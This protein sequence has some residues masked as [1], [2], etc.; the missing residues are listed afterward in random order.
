[1]FEPFIETSAFVK[2]FAIDDRVYLLSDRHIQVFDEK[3]R[4]K[5]AETQLFEKQGLA[6]S[7]I[8]DETALY[9]NDFIDLYVVD[10]VSLT[11]VTQMQLGTDLSSDIC[12]KTVDD[13]Y[14]YLGIRNGPIARIRK[15][16]WHEVAYFSLSTSSIWDL[17]L[18]EGMLYA[19]NVDG[20]LLV[21]D[22]ASMTVVQQIQAHRQNLKS[23]CLTRDLIATASQDK[24]LALWDRRTLA[25]VRTKKNAHRRAFAI[26]GIWNGCILTVSYSAG[27]IKMWE[28]DSL[29]ET[30]SLPITGCLSG[31]TLLRGPQLYLSSRAINGIDYIDLDALLA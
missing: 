28:I 10:K 12:G 7:F 25:P 11:V 22:A 13:T 18:A 4:K 17:Q 20:K 15:G 29:E 5:V 24:A 3:T 21:I 2:S 31:Q 27:E 9:C 14:V 1:M 6:R 23:L 30:A 26:V 19:G 16:N 8:T